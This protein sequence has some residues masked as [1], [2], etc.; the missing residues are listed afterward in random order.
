MLSTHLTRTA[1]M[2]MSYKVTYPTRTGVVARLTT[3]WYDTVFQRY[4]RCKCS[5]CCTILVSS[6][7]AAISASPP[8]GRT[9]Q[10]LS[11]VDSHVIKVNTSTRRTGKAV[12]GT[13][14]RQPSRVRTTP[15]PK[16]VPKRG[17]AAKSASSRRGEL[18]RYVRY[19]YV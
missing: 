3:T 1:V 5:S 15:G 14:S 7:I 17:N 6:R 11:W 16:T 12:T 9:P 19:G 8:A 13:V 2:L 4:Y 10:L 18:P